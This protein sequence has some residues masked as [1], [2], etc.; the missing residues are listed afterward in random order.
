MMSRGGMTRHEARIRRLEQSWHPATMLV[1]FTFSIGLGLW[2]FDPMLIGLSGLAALA[3]ELRFTGRRAT[4]RA[5][6]RRLPLILIVLIVN[7]LTNSLG[8]TVLTY[9]GGR[10]IT[11]E[12][13]AYGLTLGLALAVMLSWFGSYQRVMGADRSLAL[14]AG[15]LPSTALVLALSLRYIPQ[16]RRQGRELLD[17]ERAQG[18]E[19]RGRLRRRVSF[20]ASLLTQLMTLGFEQAL[21]TADA[22]QARGYGSGPRGHWQPYRLRVRDKLAIVIALALGIGLVLLARLPGA[23]V[24]F[25]P[26]LGPPLRPWWLIPAVL[27]Y[28][29]PL[30]LEGREALKWLHS[31]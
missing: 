4:A 6:L 12:A 8:L 9:I 24:R 10:P 23:G 21:A 29:L 28:G 13:L 20:A 30:L 14:L 1:W 17:L 19:G 16:L 11:V 22:M 31:T 5:M 15:R 7:P 26:W 18:H 27:L 25:F 3:W 2:R